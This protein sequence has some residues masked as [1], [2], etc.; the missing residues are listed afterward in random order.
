[1]IDFEALAEAMGDLDED[2]MTEILEEVMSEGGSQAQ[3]ALDACQKGMDTVGS[4]FEDGEYFVGDLIYAGELMTKAV[5][6]LKDGLISGD[7]TESA[8][9]KMILCTVKDDL[10]D[11][12]KNIVRS[13]L[14]AAGFDVLDLGID[15]PAEKIIETAKN[16]DIHII[17]L[18]GVLTLAIDSMKNTIDAIKEAGLR[19]QVKVI[20]GGAPVNADVCVQTGA[21]AWASSPQT[22]IDY[23]KSWAANA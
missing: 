6:I 8:K 21:D 23:C 3:E 13:M 15:V 12:G 19:D 1:M 17:G 2:V 7:G 22:T 11:I 5:E 14:E 20:I 9:T 10:H 18:S 16:E 4:L